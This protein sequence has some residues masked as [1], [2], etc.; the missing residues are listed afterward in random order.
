MKD[1]SGSTFKYNGK[2]Y[3][4]TVRLYFED[5]VEVE[6][7]NNTLE[8]FEYESEFNGLVQRGSITYTDETGKLDKCTDQYNVMC[9]VTL[10]R[11]EQQIDGQITLEKLS[12]S[13]KF[14]GMF[15][16]DNAE[17]L[18]RDSTRIKYRLNLVS[19]NIYKCLANIDYSN[20]GLSSQSCLDIIKNCAV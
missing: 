7:D 10:V 1:F 4:F 18:Q 9:Q 15:I 12:E 5:K 17:I 14:I 8:C 16:V 13:D 3:T 19:S 20:Y 6:L 2:K 11:N